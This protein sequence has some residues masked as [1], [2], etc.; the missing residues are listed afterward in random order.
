MKF[1]AEVLGEGFGVGDG[2]VG[3]ESARHGDADD[4][5]GAESGDGQGCGEC[6]VD[7]TGETDDGGF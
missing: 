4:F 3:A 1:D 5:I 2:M 7:S 6:G